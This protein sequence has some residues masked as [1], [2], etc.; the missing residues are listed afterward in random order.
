M[1]L[2]VKIGIIVSLVAVPA[3]VFFLG[4]IYFMIRDATAVPIEE[5]QLDTAVQTMDSVDRYVNERVNEL[6]VA[7]FG[8]ALRSLS[9]TPTAAAKAQASSRLVEISDPTDSWNRLDI[10]G[11]DG[12]VL[13]STEPGAIGTK[14]QEKHATVLSEALAGKVAYTDLELEGSTPTMILAIPI[15]PPEGSTQPI[16]TVLTG[17]LNWQQVLSVIKV[18]P[19]DA[20][21]MYNKDGIEIANKDN[22]DSILKENQRANPAVAD[23]LKGDSGSKTVGSQLISFTGEKGFGGYGGNGWIMTVETPTAAAFAPAT[24][25][26]IKIAVMLSLSTLGVMVAITLLIGRLVKPITTMTATANRLALGDLTQRVK[27]K[28]KNEI[29]ELGTAFNN[30]ADRLQ[31]LYKNLEAKVQQK[32]A[33]LAQ[34]VN[35]VDA[36]RAKDEAILT[37]IGE[38][39]IAVDSEGKIAKINQPAVEILG[40]QGDA[41]GKKIVDAFQLY[42]EQDTLVATENRPSVTAMASGNRSEELFVVHHKN[43]EKVK[44]AFLATPIVQQ[45]K[46]IGGIMIIRDVT[47]EREVDRMKTEFISLA[48]HQLRTPLSAIKWFSEMMVSG[49]AGVLTAEQQ[50]FVKNIY[51]STERMIDLVNSLLNI[52]RIESGRIIVDPKPTDLRELVGGIINDLKAKTEQKQQTLVVSVH[53]D[54]PKINLD[55]H[56]IGQV[57]MNFLTNAIKYTPKGGEISVFISRKGDEVV[58]QVADNGYGIPVS[59]QVKVFSKFFRAE[60][61]VKVETDGTG[62]GLYLVKA[63]IESSGG[64]VWFKSEEGKGTSFWF[65]LPMS[66]MKAKAGE[67][68]LDA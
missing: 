23:A 35:T 47:K 52:S 2:S 13:A 12:T 54:L 17:R 53:K 16:S 3:A 1:K 30:M 15:K 46:V 51:D 55:P 8:A 27:I 33:Q 29:G 44:V 48:S 11:K 7:S 32:T 62:L 66:G 31:Q 20:V 18:V 36:E 61:I 38:G 5:R 4:L 26:S 49:D 34:E 24:D 63:I 37:S 59:Q 40:L 14:L 19:R 41:F 42:D 64:K 56:L 25:I 22:P 60:N 45:G 43:G 57:Y 67:V 58:S 50:E 28:S 65:S 6:T 68:T 9:T 39:I 21:N 10:L